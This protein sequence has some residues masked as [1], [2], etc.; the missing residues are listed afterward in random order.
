[1]ADIQAEIDDFRSAVY[2]EEVRGSMISLAEKL[3]TEVESGTATVTEKATQING[4]IDR[5]DILSTNVSNN[6]SD[7]EAL[8]IVLNNN[9]NDR[10]AAENIR[11]TNEANRVANE[12]TRST[13]ENVRRSSEDTRVANENARLANET[14]RQNQESARVSKENE[15]LASENIRITNE[16]ERIANETARRSDEAIRIRSEE[17]RI[18]S[19]NL[20]ISQEDIRQNN[21][22]SRQ[23]RFNELVNLVVPP[24][25]TTEPGIV[26]VGDGLLVE[27]DGTISVVGSGDLE[28]STHAAATYA[29]KEEL[30]NALSNLANIYATIAN[31][32]AVRTIAQNALPKSA[33]SSDFEMV[34]DVLHINKNITW[35]DLDN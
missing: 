11:V 34:S 31:M 33:I 10:I 32:T 25:T 21:E 29:T 4:Y 12:T 20:R 8:R 14:T 3:N 28:T 2:G 1:M 18:A 26:I 30:T 9:E 27:E 17:N 24:A 15:R 5:L 19:E 6:L 7:S 23:S 16:N 22:R 35:N 13:N